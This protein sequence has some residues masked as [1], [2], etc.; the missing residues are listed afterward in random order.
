MN[1]AIEFLFRATRTKS[2]AIA[3]H[4]HRCYEL[5]YYG[6]GEGTTRVGDRE[7][8]YR[9]GDYAIIRPSTIHDEHRSSATDVICVG[10]PSSLLTA[11][12]EEGVFADNTGDSIMPELESMLLELREQQPR[13]DDMLELIAKRLVLRLERRHAAQTLPRADGDRFQYTIGF[14]REHFTQRIDFASLAATAGYSY[15][16]YRHLFKQKTGYSPVQYILRMR[17]DY[18]ATLLR[19][20]DLTVAAIAMECGFSTD[21]QFCNLF[22]RELGQTPGQ[23]RVHSP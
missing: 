17:L 6:Y 11:P 8:S 16:R 14:M 18:A 5:V 3:P 7:W 22:K 21:A 9:S 1:Q 15:D 19:H 10:F 12:L 2:E 23:Y 4:S 13:Y 20:S